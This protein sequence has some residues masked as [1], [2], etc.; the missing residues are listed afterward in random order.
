MLPTI[1]PALRAEF[2]PK[3]LDSR[4]A[5]RGAASTSLPSP[6][7]AARRF[8][9][10]LCEV[11][12]GM[13]P[14]AQLE[15]ACHHTLFQT[16]EQ[17]VRRSGGPAVSAHSLV[18][19]ITQEQLPGLVDAVVLIRRGLRVAAVTMRLDAAPGHWQVTELQYGSTPEREGHRSVSAT[20]RGLSG[21]TDLHQPAMAKPDAVRC[22]TTLGGREALKHACT[23]DRGHKGRC[24]WWEWHQEQV[25]RHEHARRWRHHLNPPSFR[26]AD[27]RDYLAQRFRSAPR[28]PDEPSGT[29]PMGRHPERSRG[30]GYER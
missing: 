10:A 22:G 18:D 8:A 2:T 24:S 16:L 7:S 12:A 26:L 1:A 19:V 4:D 20:T 15:R 9:M 6:G 11:E 3:E 25:A 21:A 13:R 27:Y 17:R 30:R 29:A 23:Y 5:T 14:A 28:R